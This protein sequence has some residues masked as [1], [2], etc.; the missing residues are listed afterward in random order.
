MFDW[1]VYTRRS[2]N[3]EKLSAKG[4]VGKRSIENFVHQDW[5]GIEEQHLDSSQSTYNS[6]SENMESDNEVFEIVDIES[7]KDRE[8]GE[9]AG[10]EAMRC[11]MGSQV[12]KFNGQSTNEENMGDIPEDVGNHIKLTKNR[13]KRPLGSQELEMDGQP[14][15]EG[16]LI[17]NTKALAQHLKIGNFGVTWEEIKNAAGT[18]NIELIEKE[19][20]AVTSLMEDNGDKS[21]RRRKGIERELHNLNFNIS[22]ERKRTEMGIDGDS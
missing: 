4:K 3:I 5:Q 11:L 16:N 10:F 21:T 13:D 12:S 6:S 17:D 20:K 14:V 1:K 15:K 9:E 8:E 19:A 22:Y 18:L 2:K 7:E